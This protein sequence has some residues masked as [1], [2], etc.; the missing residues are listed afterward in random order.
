MKGLVEILLSEEVRKIVLSLV[1]LTVII[2]LW[3]KKC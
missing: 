3:I 2:D 1:L